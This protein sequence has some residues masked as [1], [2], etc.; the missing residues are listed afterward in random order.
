MPKKKTYSRSDI[1]SLYMEYAVE[2]D[3]SP[4]VA[5]FCAETGVADEVFHEYFDTI[6]E[7]ERAVWQELVRSSIQ[8]VVNDELYEQYERRDKLSAFYYTF[9]ENLSLNRDFLMVSIKAHNPLKMQYVWTP[10]RVEFE[11]YMTHLFDGLIDIP[12]KFA[13]GAT[14]IKEKA[15]STAFWG[16]LVFLI[17][18]WKKDKSDDQEK[19]DVAIEKTVKATMDLI[20]VTPIKSVIDWGKFI[21]QERGAKSRCK[22]ENQEPK[23]ESI[24]EDDR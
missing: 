8:T 14:K 22:K 9:F 15:I 18:F 13:K 19:T 23:E 10:M 20:D 17:D 6:E 4:L 11:E 7:V 24:D 2:Q 3:I 12:S 1:I 21:W 16:Q 5:E